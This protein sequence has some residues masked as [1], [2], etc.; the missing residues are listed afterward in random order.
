[1]KT[2]TDGKIQVK[3]RTLIPYDIEGK[4]EDIIIMLQDWETEG[5]WEGIECE[6]I[7]YDGAVECYLYKHRPETDGEYNIRM[8]EMEKQKEKELKKREKRRQQYEA[9]K[10]EFGDT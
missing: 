6:S 8:K 1:M 9:L 5:G 7:G 2:I 3:E 4:L 10:K